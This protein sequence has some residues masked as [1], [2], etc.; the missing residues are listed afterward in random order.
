MRL[1]EVITDDLLEFEHAGAGDT[2]EPRAEPLVEVRA[3]AL[4]KT[5]VR[6]I[7]EQDVVEA[8]RGVARERRLHRVYELLSF[9]GRDRCRGPL[10]WL[11]CRELL[12]GAAL[13]DRTGDGAGLEDAL[14]LD[15]QPVDARAE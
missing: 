4:E 12:H 6:G 10:S 13:E 7:P 2:L 14:L 15:G 8:M 3:G 11:E 1:L 5:L 9:E